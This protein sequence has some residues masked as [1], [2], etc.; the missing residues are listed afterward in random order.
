MVCVIKQNISFV[1]VIH[2]TLCGC[3]NI[4][5][6]KNWYKSIPPRAQKIV[7]DIAM[8]I[9]IPVFFLIVS[10]PALLIGTNMYFK[11]VCVLTLMVEIPAGI[12][13]LMVL[14]GAFKD[15]EIHFACGICFGGMFLSRIL[16]AYI[17][18]TAL[19][20]ITY[21]ILILVSIII[22]QKIKLNKQGE[23]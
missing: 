15:Y 11:F 1:C 10:L 22:F 5:K 23:K 9:L 2:S 19:Y 6:I 17:H 7:W 20:V 18:G 12:T 3:F 21:G 8:A 13:I 14:V 16:K 4:N